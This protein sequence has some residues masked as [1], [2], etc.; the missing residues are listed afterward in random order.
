MGIPTILDRIAQE[1]IRT[2]LEPKVEP[3]FHESSFG[4]RRGRSC[5]QAVDKTLS[6]CMTNDWVI[7][8]DIQGFF[9]S[10]DHELLLKAVAHYCKDKWV[11]LY[12]SRWLKAGIM[13]ADGAKV[14]RITGTPQGGVVS[15]LLAN[16]FL[17]VAFDGWMQKHH[18]EK[19][20]VRYADD[21]AP[22]MPTAG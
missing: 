21:S 17:H 4:Y 2:H 5:H 11:L 18:P 10:I 13:Q 20:F 22:R 15:P 19:P 6:N 1:I 16:I 8:L 7:D 3:L 14:N 12:I 9:D